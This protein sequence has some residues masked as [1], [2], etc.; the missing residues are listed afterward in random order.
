[1]RGPVSVQSSKAQFHIGYVSVSHMTGVEI[2]PDS[3]PSRQWNKK[4][5]D[6][7]LFEAHVVFLQVRPL[8]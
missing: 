3:R 6:T 2:P 1:M 4:F 7:R 5:H 8:T